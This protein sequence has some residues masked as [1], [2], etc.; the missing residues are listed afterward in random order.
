MTEASSPEI[1][2]SAR[3]KIKAS[4]RV[5]DVGLVLLALPLLIPVFVIICG[6]IMLDGGAPIYGHRRLGQGGRMFPCLKF[7]TMVRDGDSILRRLCATN[8]AAEREWHEYRKLSNDPRVTR[9]GR[10]LRA[11]SLDE[12][13]QLVN[14][15]RG[16][17]S[18]VG[19]R[20][21]T[22]EEAELYETL[23]HPVYRRLRPGITGLWQ[24]SE[25]NSAKVSARL[26]HDLTYERQMSVW[27]DLR[28]LGRTVGVVISRSGC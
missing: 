25:R 7:R 3:S 9:L 2:L 13:P 23:R 20:P 5:L 8:P 19:P 24:V 14:V 26:P 4:K 22:R 28:I 1:R 10:V 12:L 16:E 21:F 15:L 17:M 18:L 27:N 6:L 11:T